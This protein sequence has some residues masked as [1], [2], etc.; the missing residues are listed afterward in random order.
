MAE[1][2]ELPLLSDNNLNWGEKWWFT[3]LKGEEIFWFCLI[4]VNYTAG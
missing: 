3:Q 4:Y 1:V 2:F